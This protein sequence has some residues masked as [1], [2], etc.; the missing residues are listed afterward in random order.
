MGK[1]FGVHTYVVFYQK[2]FVPGQHIHD[3]FPQRDFPNE[4]ILFRHTQPGVKKHLFHILPDALGLGQNPAGDVR[5][6]IFAQQLDARHRQ[7]DFMDPLFQKF[8]ILSGL[9]LGGSHLIR[10][11]L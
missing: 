5:L 7:L 2:L 3:A 8:L 6:V 9:S 10:H 11:R 1:I 4:I